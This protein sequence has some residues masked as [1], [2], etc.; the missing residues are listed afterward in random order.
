[1]ATPAAPTTTTPIT[2]YITDPSSIASYNRGPITSIFS[3]PVSCLE[4]LT[5]NTQSSMLYF[6]HYHASYYDAA[7]YPPQNKNAIPWFNMYYYSPAICPQPWTIATFFTTSSPG[8][9]STQ[10][11]SIGSGTTVAL[12]CPPGYGYQTMG[13][14]CGSMITQNQVVRYIVPTGNSPD[15][16]GAP[17]WT[18]TQRQ[19]SMVK[20]DAV[21]IW[22]Q[23]KDMDMLAA[24]L[25][26]TSSPLAT[27]SAQTSHMT[28][29]SSPTGATIS[30]SASQKNG[31]SGLS[32]GAKAGIGVGAFIVV[33]ALAL[34][35]FFA[36]RRKRSV[37]EPK[38]A[39]EADQSVESFEKSG[40]SI[41]E[42][43]NSGMH[44]S[45]HEIPAPAP[46]LA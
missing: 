3:P 11:I 7:C 29:I 33:A 35:L 20:G 22:W 13:H 6:G 40:A 4:T 1:M 21:P 32:T 27:S 39:H 5:T 8:A 38:S 19:S 25:T 9:Y 44:S 12:C 42:M 17:V 14:V 43:D 2:T 10:W 24:A 34:A 30:D 45:R 46:E 28:P 23:A 18:L 41:Y 31:S 26:T 15:P 16:N 36:V 37:V